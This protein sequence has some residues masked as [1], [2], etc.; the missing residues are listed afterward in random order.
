[1]RMNTYLERKKGFNEW[2]SLNEQKWSNFRERYRRCE[3]VAD[4]DRGP[5][6][7][8][9]ESADHGS[10]GADRTC[11]M[12]KWSDWPL[13]AECGRRSGPPRPGRRRLRVAHEG[14][15]PATRSHE[16][17]LAPPQPG[18]PSS[19]HAQSQHPS[20]RLRAIPRA[21]PAA[22]EVRSQHGLAFSPLR[23]TL[24]RPSLPSKGSRTIVDFELGTGKRT[25]RS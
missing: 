18:A 10:G 24:Q 25:A 4:S 8:G 12:A 3:V 15:S 16:F 9:A 23:G 21:R 17:D 7:S 22:P 20:P 19:V 5:W 14:A 1:M 11:V 2:L 13:A 6:R